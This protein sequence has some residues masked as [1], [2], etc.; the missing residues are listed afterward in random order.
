LCEVDLGGDRPVQIACGAANVAAGQRVPVA[1]VGTTLLLPSRQNPQEREPVTINRARIR[2]ELS[3]GMICAE[4]ELGLTEDHSGIMLLEDSARLGQPFSEY[5]REREV[6]QS[7][8]VLD[9]GITPNRPDAASHIGVARDVAA[10]TGTSLTIPP[11]DLPQNGGDA[12]GQVTIEILAPEGCPRYVAMLV[13]GVE[14]GESPSWLQRR[15]EAIGLRPRNVVVDVTNFVLHESGQP[16]H[17]FD[18]DQLSGSKIRVRRTES[19]TRFTTLDSKARLLPPGTLMI[20]DAE[21]DVAIAGVMG[22]ENSE[23]TSAT[24]NVLIESAYFDP[25]SIRKT[26]KALD[27]Q[28]DASYRFERGV[29]RDGQVWAAARAAHL[30]ADLAGGSIVDG[31]VDAHPV[32]LE[33][34][35]VVLRNSRVKKLLGVDIPIDRT[36]ALLESIG[37][38]VAGATNHEPILT[39]TVP[40]FRPDVEREVDLIEE[41]VRLF[42][43]ENISEPERSVAPAL[44]RRERAV[45]RL[46]G[47]A[48]ALLSSTGY[49]EIYTNSM[50]RAETARTFLAAGGGIVETL[51]PISQEMAALRPSLLP[52]ALQVM[53][54]NQKHGQKYLRFFELGHIYRK[55]NEPS[56]LT[57]GYEEHESLI[58]AAS[59]P[60]TVRGWDVGERTID[61]FDV[62]GVLETLLS[63]IHTPALRFE[64]RAES[65]ATSSHQLGIYSR[66]THLGILARVSDDVADSFDLKEPVF[67]A[68]LNW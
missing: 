19:E 3:E 8:F 66:E 17:A 26:A 6:E 10:L 61:L 18:F 28:T 34:R 49:R 57:P 36:A 5:L 44:V 23:V 64:S 31:M 32:P 9:V 39:C 4:D 60:A 13:R 63:S 11:I 42:G 51:N 16:L 21:R 1:T 54:F 45:D 46:R 33:R 2:G 22:G 38:E 7:D 55:T 52:G 50:Q 35:R 62:K 12:A 27:L 58:V 29:D 43:Y 41:V 48:R 20:C 24:R 65:G 47:S 56:T 67:F 15:L 14:V 59:G 53:G 68:E 40:T 37:F 30:I 25:T